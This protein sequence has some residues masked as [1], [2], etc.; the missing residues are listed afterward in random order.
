MKSL[1]TALKALAPSIGKNC[2]EDERLKRQVQLDKSTARMDTALRESTFDAL[3]TDSILDCAVLVTHSNYEPKAIG[4]FYRD[5]ADCENGFDE[6]KNQ[7]GWG[8]YTT[9]DLERCN[10]SA[11]AVVRFTTGGA[12]TCD[13]RIRPLV[14]RPSRHAH[15]C[16]QGWRD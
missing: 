2:T 14:W 5:R 3:S 10:H 6:L 15:C 7:W 11:R 1:R 8:G 12:G 16:L 13:W 9:Q 4:Q